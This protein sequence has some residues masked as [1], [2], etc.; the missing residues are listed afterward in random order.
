[1]TEVVI[2]ASALLAFLKGEER[3]LNE[4]E[5]ILPK[6]LI[7]SVNFCEVATILG[8]LGMPK[9]IIEE[10]VEETVGK[11]VSFDD[12]QALIAAD[13]RHLTKPYGLSLGDRACLA[14]GLTYKLPVYTADKIWKKIDI[15]IPIELIR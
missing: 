6:A 12:S 14:L 15:D 10:V 11:I 1:M 5:E 3:A 9:E 7:S 4:L 2:D 8:G 13:L